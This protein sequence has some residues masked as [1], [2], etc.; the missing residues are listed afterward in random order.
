MLGVQAL[1][2]TPAEAGRD[3]RA[4]L[5]Q[6]ES[7]KSWQDGQSPDRHSLRHHNL[8]ELGVALGLDLHAHRA[9]LP[10]VLSVN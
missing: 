5:W 10:V 4:H 9:V 6:A 8:E 2:A 1:E 7:F 3:R